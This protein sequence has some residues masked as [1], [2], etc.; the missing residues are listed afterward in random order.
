MLD[1]THDPTAAWSATAGVFEVE[2]AGDFSLSTSALN[3]VTMDSFTCYE[4]A[5][6]KSEQN[7]ALKRVVGTGPR[8]M[9]P[10]TDGG[11]RH[12]DHESCNRIKQ[13][14]PF[15]DRTPVGR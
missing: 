8:S 2:V 4:T 9:D 3:A 7:R 6:Q 13:R 1:I 12:D 15:V 5:I 10:T 11:Q 14:R